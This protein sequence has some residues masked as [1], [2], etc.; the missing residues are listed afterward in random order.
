MHQARMQYY[1]EMTNTSGALQGSGPV[2]SI[3]SAEITRRIN[4]AGS[5]TMVIAANDLQAAYIQ[6][7]YYAKV[8]MIHPDSGP[9]T[10]TRM[11]IDQ[12]DYEVRGGH[13]YIIATGDDIVRELT[14]RSVGFTNYASGTNPVSVGTALATT[15][16]FTP[17]GWGVWVNATPPNDNF[18]YKATGESVLTILGKI[19]EQSGL[20][21][22]SN[23]ITRHI[24]FETVF[25]DSG[26]R[27]I[28]PGVNS[29]ADSTTAFIRSIR[30]TYDSYRLISRIYPY[31]E[32]R[33]AGTYVNLSA[34][35]RIPVAGY[36]LD[37]VAN[38]IKR[39]STETAYGRIERYIQYSEI[40]ELSAAPGDA[41]SAANALYD[42]A[43]NELKRSSAAATLYDIELSRCMHIFR[44][45][46]SL[47]VFYRKTI[48]AVNVIDIDAT[49]NV[50]ESTIRLRAGMPM[51][52]TRLLVGSDD[53]QPR[54]DKD[55]LITLEKNRQ[56]K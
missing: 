19:A 48:D 3:V 6:P 11:I 37:A 34:T 2:T 28:E 53:Y 49:L 46:E 29:V 44:P 12:I 39:N 24:E 13:L 27:A 26:V 5:V 52:T 54:T 32:K 33:A 7:H 50:L 17:P 51:E 20:N 55:V 15:W 25:A 30:R 4:K 42:V 40:K 1:A 23:G 38:Y 35:N 31:G 9:I 18:Y 45:M 16:A 47:R 36:T 56:F 10:L 21:F 41:T 43:Y 14:W 22:Y 8:Y